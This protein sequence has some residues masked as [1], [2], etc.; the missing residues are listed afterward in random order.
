MRNEKCVN[1]AFPESN[2]RRDELRLVSYPSVSGT[3]ANSAKDVG[4]W[5]SVI[6]DGRM[7]GSAQGALSGLDASQA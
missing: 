3:L 1:T 6:A 5:M 7:R 4:T 2:L